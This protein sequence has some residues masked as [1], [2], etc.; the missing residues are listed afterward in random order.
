MGRAGTA[1]VSPCALVGKDP[2][3]DH[4]MDSGDDE[5][6]RDADGH[7]DKRHAKVLRRRRGLQVWRERME[8]RTNLVWVL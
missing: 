4:R 2:E 5:P 1:P 3:G 6:L 8:T 7:T